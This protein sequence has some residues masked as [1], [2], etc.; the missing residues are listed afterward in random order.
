MKR[1]LIALI[2]AAVPIIGSAQELAP[3][4]KREADSCAIALLKSDYEGVARYTHERLIKV[5]GGKDQMIA[6]IKRGISQMHTAGFDFIETKT[7]TPAEPKRVGS[8]LTSLVPTTVVMK[9]PDGRRMS[10]D[11]FLLGISEDNG[12]TWVFV[13][14]SNITNEQYAELFPELVREI[15]LP[16]KKKAVF[17]NEKE[18]NQASP[19]GKI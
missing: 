15:P 7:G 14:L 6:E 8:W 11:S 3:I 1:I 16:A 9:V 13:D 12:K 10:K 2:L 4:V 19:L 18:P 5:M 17:V